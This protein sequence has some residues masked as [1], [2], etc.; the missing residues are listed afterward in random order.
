MN[1]AVAEYLKLAQE[2]IN[3]NKWQEAQVNFQKAIQIQPNRWDL[4]FNLGAVFLKQQQYQEAAKYFQQAIL[5]KPE[6]DKSYNNLGTALLKLEQTDNAVK[7]FSQA[8]ALNQQEP[9]FYYNL[10]EALVQQ[11]LIDRALICFRQAVKLDPQDHQLQFRLGKSF[12]N[13]GL[14]QEAITCFCR[15]IELNP[16]YSPAYIS[17]RYVD[18]KL[19]LC[20]R[21]ISFYRQILVKHPNLSDALTNLAEVLT[22]QGNLAEAISISRR[23]IYIKTVNN[24]P[25][26]A[27]ANWSVKK[28]Q[29]PDFIIIGAGKC[30]T[31]SL[32]NYLGYHPQV[33]LPNKKELRFFDKNFAY[34]YEWYLA[35]FPAISDRRD[36]ITGEASPSYFFLPHVAQRIRDFAPDIKLIVML[37][38]PVER[39]ISDYYQ[40]KKTGRNHQSL[41]EVIKR[42]TERFKQKTEL[43]L[44][45]HGGP[46]LQS[47]YYY[48][49]KRWLKIFPKEQLLIIKSE[50]F[51][52]NTAQSMQQVFEF[53]NLSN[54]A[55]D[56]YQT[57]NIGSYSQVGEDIQEQLS[58][59]FEPHNKRLEEYLEIIFNW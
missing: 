14:N 5:I 24:H 3:Q 47:L 11:G 30:G 23:A 21:L 35:Q 18:L 45:Y 4:Y 16:T 10:G 38:N 41:L 27:Q 36:L 6:H 32:Y 57:Y 34:G 51:F 7:A 19:E 56:N 29:A 54:I 59:F 17:L 2:K 49:L 46:L 55:I 50:N 42:E 53:L 40:N 48:K 33:L 31:T 13:Q 9:Q 1:Q 39:S 15:A 22:Y 12:R 20:N 28:K 44:S 58:N 37:R 43:E 8:V 52:N 26:L 25:D